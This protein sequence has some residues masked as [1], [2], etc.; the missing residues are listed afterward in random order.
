MRY[1][2]GIELPPLVSLELLRI[3]Q[4]IS[5]AQVCTASWVKPDNLHCTLLFLGNLTEQKL[6]ALISPLSTIQYPPFFTELEQL[7][8]PRWSSPHLIWVTLS[9]N[10]LSDLYATLCKELPNY[11]ETRSFTGHCTIAR[12]KKVPKQGALKELI[13][14]IEIAPL[15]WEVTS[16]SLYSSRTEQMGAEYTL[17]KRYIL[18]S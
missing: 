12:L 14:S 3:Q 18:K 13:E 8:V 17:I 4:I 2:I 15:S 16:F 11:Q 6:T 5:E 1:F 10:G 7:E 9:N